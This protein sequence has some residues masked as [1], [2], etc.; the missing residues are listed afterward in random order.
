LPR[1]Q[2]LDKHLFL[3]SESYLTRTDAW[4]QWN[5]IVSRGSIAHV[6]DNALAYNMLV[7]AG[8]GIGLLGSYAVLEPAAVPLEIDVRI[9]LPL[10]ALALEERLKVKAVRVVL[11]WLSELFGPANPWFA[12][13][14]RLDVEPSPYDAGFKS[15]FNLDQRADG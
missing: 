14:F 8:L 15:M 3:Q 12:P 5:Y 7:K 6:C 1:R 2:N 11:D 9:S 10:Y 13:E 4:A